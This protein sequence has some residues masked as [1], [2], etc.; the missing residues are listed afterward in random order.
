M[1][2][3]ALSCPEQSLVIAH[4]RFAV[5]NFLEQFWF[6]GVSGMSEMCVVLHRWF[7]RHIVM[8][9]VS[10]RMGV[11]CPS[12]EYISTLMQWIKC[13]WLDISY[14]MDI[15]CVA[16]VAPQLYLNYIN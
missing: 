7:S 1:W 11:S 4:T 6:V 3:Y 8:D 10:W 5:G 14:R 2:H 15:F 13:A 12:R 9:S 16:K